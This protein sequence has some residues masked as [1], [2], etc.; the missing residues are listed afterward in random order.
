V[1]H[2]SLVVAQLKAAEHVLHAW[3]S[4]LVNPPM[5]HGIRS[6]TSRVMSK[7]AFVSLATLA[8][9]LANRGAERRARALAG[10]VSA[11]PRDLMKTLLR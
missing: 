1:R 11:I 4:A 9:Y 3:I 2:S 5:K 8:R 6:W 10:R 7:R